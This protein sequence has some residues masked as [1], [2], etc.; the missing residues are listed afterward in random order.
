MGKNWY[1][2][3]T[4]LALRRLLREHMMATDVDIEVHC[5][6][7]TFTTLLYGLASKEMTAEEL[8]TEY[9][10]MILPRATKWSAE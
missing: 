1:W 10:V 6:V 4:S 9:Q 8:D 5:N 3:L 2:S 7:L